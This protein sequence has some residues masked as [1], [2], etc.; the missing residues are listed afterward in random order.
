MSTQT[1]M[2]EAEAMF[3]A[4]RKAE[5]RQFPIVETAEGKVRGLSSGVQRCRVRPICWVS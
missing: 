2:T 1:E 5:A 4:V 3:A